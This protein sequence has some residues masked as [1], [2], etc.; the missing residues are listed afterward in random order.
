MARALMEALDRVAQHDG[1]GLMV[2]H[3]RGRVYK[4]GP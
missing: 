3:R 1:A 2:L 4:T